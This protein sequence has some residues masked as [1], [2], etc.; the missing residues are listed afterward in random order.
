MGRA[1]SALLLSFATS[2]ALLGVLLAVTP[3]NTHKILPGLL[4][5][6]PI[7]VTLASLA[8]FL[9]VKRAGVVLVGVSVAGFGLIEALKHLGWAGI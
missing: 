2:V 1:L 8:Y 9:D 5:F 4:L 7:W 3:E 6:F